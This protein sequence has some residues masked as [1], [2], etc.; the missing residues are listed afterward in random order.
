MWIIFQDFLLEEYRIVSKFAASTSKASD[1]HVLV[2][3]T[4]Q[5]EQ[6]FSFHRSCKNCIDHLLYWDTR[7]CSWLRYWATRLKAAGFIPDGV[8][9]NQTQSFRPHYGPGV[10][11]A[12][13]RNEYQ[14]YILRVK[15][16][17][18]QGLIN[19]APS[20]ADCLKVCEPHTPG[21]LVACNSRVQW[22]IYRNFS[23]TCIFCVFYTHTHTH[24]HTHTDRQTDTAF[25]RPLR[26][27]E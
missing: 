8:T 23:N 13:N 18:Y 5:K 12:S 7:W 10:D 20:C 26:F 2:M 27:S 16:S 1:E 3:W 24:T 11:S 6:N 17:R 19:L 9:E 15:G 22:A 4:E 21:K 25:G 14:E